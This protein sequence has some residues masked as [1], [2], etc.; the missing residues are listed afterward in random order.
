MEVLDIVPSSASRMISLPSGEMVALR[1][2]QKLR[3]GLL[4]GPT[5]FP[6]MAKQS[7]SG[8]GPRQDFKRGGLVLR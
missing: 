5:G 1:I 4:P 6:R 2:T 3:F 7:V 8:E